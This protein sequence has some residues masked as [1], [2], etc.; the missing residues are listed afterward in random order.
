MIKTK[1]NWLK[2]EQDYLSNSGLSL[3]DI[4]LQYGVSYSRVKKVSME[5]GW[6]QKRQELIERG[7]QQIE[8]EAEKSITEQVKQHRRDATYIKNT[9]L[10]EIKGRVEGGLLGNENLSALVRLLDIGMRELR[11]LFPKNIVVK[12][13][14]PE[15]EIS[16]ELKQAAHEALIKIVTEK[17]RCR[18]RE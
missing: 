11:E 3:M 12:E 5:K 8:E 15:I 10:A 2:A 16:P 17:R 9:V 18:H 14:L 4:S 1:I 7:K 6:H 13:N